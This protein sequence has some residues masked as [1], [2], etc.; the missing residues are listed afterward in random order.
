M[1]VFAALAYGVKLV[2]RP[3]VIWEEM[4][5]LPGRAG[6]AAGTAGGLAVA[7]VL[8]PYAPELA[9]VALFGGLALHGMLALVVL[10]ALIG[11]PP[12]AR[13]VTP[14]FHLSFVGFIIGGLAAVPLGH[15][16]L[17]RGLLWAMV[18]VAGLIWG[19]SLVQLLRRVPPAPL[20]PMLAI[21]LAPAAL[22]SIVAG[23]VGFEGLSLSFAVLG[24]GILLALV[25]AG[26]W[27]IEAG[28]SPMWGAFT[29][30]L[31]AYA[32][33]LIRL[34][35]I[36]LWAGVG[37]LVVAVGVVPLVLW[38]VLKM[39]PGGKLAAKTNAAEA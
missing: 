23:L 18:P 28:F 11:L 9:R 13:G 20:R 38:R 37:V 26:A 4:K 14:A 1:W 34:E 32:A 22:F 27:V 5:V 24:A 36:F 3:G 17:A 6:L 12:E 29:F 39:W 21:H 35:G 25:V 8:V 33:A 2:R 15:E 16:A 31:A 30:P 7:A 10:R 19:A